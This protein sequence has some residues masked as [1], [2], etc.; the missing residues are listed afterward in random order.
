MDILIH[1]INIINLVT[2]I[3]YLFKKKN[4]NNNN[5]NNNKSSNTPNTSN[6]EILIINNNESSNNEILIINNNESSNNE[7]LIINN[8]NE[9]SNDKISIINKVIENANFIEYIN[10]AIRYT[11]EED[12]YYIYS[13]IPFIII[14]NHN[15]SW[16]IYKPICM[17]FHD[18]TTDSYD[19]NIPCKFNEKKHSNNF[20]QTCE[21]LHQRIDRVFN[22]FFGNHQDIALLTNMLTRESI[23]VINN[24][25]MQI[26]YKFRKNIY[27][28]DY[29]GYNDS[30]DN[31]STYDEMNETR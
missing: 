18:I 15:I 16:N 24:I 8:N 12:S 20:C 21:N 5:N 28:S 31:E 4:N 13:T 14:I 25:M 1:G 19:Y 23:D 11:K 17:E 2:N 10:E 29:H 26:S 6:N 3:I 22:D 7:I 30:S 9:S 27:Y